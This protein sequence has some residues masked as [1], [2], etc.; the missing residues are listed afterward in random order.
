MAVEDH[1]ARTAPVTMRVWARRVSE[2]MGTDRIGWVEMELAAD[3]HEVQWLVFVRFD[4]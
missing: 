4:L 1:R 3:W 2:R